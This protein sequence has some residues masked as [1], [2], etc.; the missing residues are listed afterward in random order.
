[1]NTQLDF[2]KIPDQLTAIVSANGKPLQGL[3]VM[4][5]LE[6]SRKNRFNIV[7]GPSNEKGTIE[8]SKLQ[9]ENEVAKTRK[10]FPV[11]YEDLSSFKGTITVGVMSSGQVNSALNA[12]DQYRCSAS[13]PPSYREKLETARRTLNGLGS[14]KLNVKVTTQRSNGKTRIITRSV[15]ARS[16]GNQVMKRSG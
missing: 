13:Y 8:I 1:M 4:V 15:V 10:M 11:D 16:N 5:S 2:P 9:I 7:F 6:M 14:K 3:L 12:Y